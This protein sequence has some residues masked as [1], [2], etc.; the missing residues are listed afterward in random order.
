MII[1]ISYATRIHG[2]HH[3]IEAYPAPS[4]GAVIGGRYVLYQVRSLEEALELALRSDADAVLYSKPDELPVPNAHEMRL[5]KDCGLA[6]GVMGGDP[7]SFEPAFVW[8]DTVEQAPL[9]GR[10][11][12]HGIWDCYSLVR[13]AFRCG[14]E[15]MAAQGLA[16]WPFVPVEMP[17]VPRDDAWWNQGQD[18]YMD[19]LN[20]AGFIQIDE[21]Q[22]R[23][24]DGFLMKIRSNVLNHAGLLID[25]NTILHHLPTR[26]SRRENGGV[27]F[28]QIEM[29]VRYK[30]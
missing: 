25:D 24:G 28:R 20:P 16:H 30:G 11:F 2:Q 5:Q 22:A 7:A 18:L 14:R 1:E 13:D 3:A 9:I 26:L 12:V 27:W 8:G 15:K 21:A 19:W 10:S 17:H 6:F 23:P 4:F 29:W